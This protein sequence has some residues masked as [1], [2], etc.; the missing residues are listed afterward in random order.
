MLACL[1]DRLYELR[2]AN[3]LGIVHVERQEVLPQQLA[4]V[5]PREATAEGLHRAGQL[6]VGVSVEVELLV[7]FFLLCVYARVFVCVSECVRDR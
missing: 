4:A 7:V 5:G 3:P 2:P 1:V 6:L